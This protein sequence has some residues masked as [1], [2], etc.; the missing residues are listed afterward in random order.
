MAFQISPGINVSEIDL[1]TIVPAVG[2]TV[3]AIAGPFR[4]GPANKPTL[5]DSE[6]TL[7]STFGKPDNASANTWFTSANFLSY[8]SALQAVRVVKTGTNGH[9]NATADGSGLLIANED[10]Y[11][12]NYSTGTGNVGMF[13]AKYAGDLG[14]SLTVSLADEFSFATWT[15]KGYFDSAP[16]TSAVV[17]AGGGAH[18]E[19]HVVVIDSLGFWTGTPGTVLERFPFL[20]KSAKA[21]SEDGSTMYYPE[22]LNRKSKYI[23]WMDHPVAA[24]LGQ[25]SLPNWGGDQTVTFDTLSDKITVSGAVGTFTVGETVT[26]TAAV[27]LSPAGTG[28]VATAT[29]T[30]G[31]ITA[32]TVSNGGTGYTVAPTVVITPT[33]GDTITTN[34]TATAQVANGVVTGVTFTG[35]GGYAHVPTITFVVAGS[36]ATASVTVDS[37][38]KITA[39]TALTQGTGYL[40]APVVTI[41]G[42]GSGA[43]VT[44]NLG[45]GQTATKVVSYTVVSGGT[46]YSTISGKLLAS[47]NSILTISPI[48]GT[49]VASNVVTGSTSGATATVTSVGGGP[50]TLPLTGG[51]DANALLLDGDYITGYDLFKSGEDIDVS[52]V[53]GADA[54]S[55]VAIDLIG[56]IAE[57]RKDCVVFLSPPK[58]S[59]V[60][61][62]GHESDDI[63]AFRN[64][65]PSSSYA[66]MDCNWKYQYDKYNDLFRWIPLNGDVAGLCVRT[67]TVRDPWWSPAGYNRG[68]IKNVVRLAWNP[69]KAFRDLLYQNG[70][71]AVM[72][73]PGQGTLLFGDKTLLAKPSAFD[74]INVRRL[75]IVL[76]KAIATAAK[77]T[78]FEFNDQFTQASF[79]SMIEPYLRDVKGR[80]GIYDYRVVCDSTNNTPQVQDSN[81]FVGDIYVKPARSINFIQL[82]FVAVRTG[83][84][85]EEI[86]GK[87]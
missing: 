78:L 87:F 31:A 68:L 41:T 40:S 39:I 77:F 76:E 43:T 10:A 35:G 42:P 48:V 71:N 19:L 54:S 63:I 29:V 28:A 47:A 60:D 32:I 24:D 67:D 34:A 20:S 59:V 82:N 83:V 73:E 80:R 64:L 13:A 52:L 49:F 38:G 15:Y 7:A 56:N 4:W 81:Q 3:G 44:A 37:T 30:S 51:V 12:N 45:M 57:Y 26:D 8:A 50:I 2:T 17:S 5:I 53:L 23:Y 79:R 16:N 62:A 84:S 22:V 1:T 86:V 36:G 75:F 65:L 6:L 66:F 72:S 58:N 14:N 55:V 18:D 61:N 21:K 27:V 85:F 9:K 74:R 33:G 11:L 25:T 69:R 46:G 70:V